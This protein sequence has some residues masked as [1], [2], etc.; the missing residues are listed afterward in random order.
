M[1]IPEK[2]LHFI[3]QHQ[4]YQQNNLITDE[5]EQLAILHQGVNNP[6]QGPDFLDATIRIKDIKLVGNIEL[7][8]NS[9]DWNA[10]QHSMDTNYNTVILH[11]VWNND[12]IIINKNGQ[13]IPQLT[14]SNLVPKWLL[15]RYTQLMNTPD[16]LPCS[17]FLP[18]INPLIWTNWKE[19]LTIE[20]LEEK[21]A[22]ILSMYEESNHHWEEVLWWMI[23]YNFGLKLNA[24]LFLQVAKS[25]PINILGKHKNQVFQIEAL[26]MGQAN[27][28]KENNT[29]VEDESLYKLRKEYKF[30]QQ[31]YSLV[32]ISI[33][34]VFLRMR[35]SGFPTIRIAQLSMLIK[36]SQHLFSTI[37]DI[38]EL[39]ALKTLLYVSTSPYWNNHYVFGK[40]SIEREKYTGD[41]MIDNII[42]NTIIPILFAYGK[43][44]KDNSIKDRMLVWLNALVPE[45]NYVLN[46]WIKEGISNDTA[47]DS[48]GLLQLR[49][50][51]C[52]KKRCMECAIGNAIISSAKNN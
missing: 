16:A 3:W 31:K 19:R 20:R 34:P 23:A 24:D 26:L 25:I 42:I 2:L 49:K 38:R 37:K 52:D 36:Q 41:T 8:I 29:I 30:L 1:L 27:L 13:L 28:L 15:D 14:I 46:S 5:G 12:A 33:S 18:Y 11:V 48:Q 32:P 21:T 47:F 51:Y 44:H 45:N 7:H 17:N 6:N 10:H 4:Y 50:H 22:K 35:P 9:S 40:E 43:H 39:K